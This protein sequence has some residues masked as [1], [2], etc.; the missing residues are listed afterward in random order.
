MTVRDAV[1]IVVL[2]I[3][4]GVLWGP[5]RER[6]AEPFR[7][8]VYVVAGVAIILFALRLLGF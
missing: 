5:L 6:V 8:L 1:Y 3:I 2:L 7:T 4:C